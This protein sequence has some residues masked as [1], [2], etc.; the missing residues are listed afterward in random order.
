LKL[1]D[2]EF[3]GN[4]TLKFTMEEEEIN[5]EVTVA[6]LET[7]FLS[8]ES[9]IATEFEDEVFEIIDEGGFKVVFGMVGR[10]I[11]EVKDVAIAK[12]SSERFRMAILWEFSISRAGAL[13][14]ATVDL[15]IEFAGTVAFGSGEFEIE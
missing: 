7:V 11:E 6:N 14:D 5:E 15:A 8:K 2:F 3:K 13:K 10:Q 12:N 4:E 9:E 1:I